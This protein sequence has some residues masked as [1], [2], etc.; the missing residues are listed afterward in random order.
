MLQEYWCTLAV[1][2]LIV[3]WIDPCWKTSGL[4]AFTLRLQM[5]NNVW[6]QEVN[7]FY[8]KDQEEEFQDR[9]WE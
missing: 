2:C 5:E 3:H 8:Q 1:I 7:S 9:H 6:S 4:Q